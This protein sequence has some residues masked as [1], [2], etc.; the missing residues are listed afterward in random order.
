MFFDLDEM[1][2]VKDSKSLL[3]IIEE[4]TSLIREKGG[5]VKLADN[6]FSRQITF[7]NNTFSFNLS[8]SI[9]LRK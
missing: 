6:V 5:G 9:P 1:K 8:V 4:L 2:Y 3:Q 7:E